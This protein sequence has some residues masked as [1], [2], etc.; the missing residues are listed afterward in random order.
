MGKSREEMVGWGGRYWGL[1]SE[2]K[3]PENKNKQRDERNERERERK[4]RENMHMN[5][6][7]IPHKS[8][9]LKNAMEILK[10]RNDFHVFFSMRNKVAIELSF[11]VWKIW[12]IE[13]CR[14]AKAEHDAIVTMKD[15]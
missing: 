10:I 15:A 7:S 3:N 4:G 12:K 11:F 2:M 6:V 14:Q 13:S 8:P 5:L 1:C 9:G